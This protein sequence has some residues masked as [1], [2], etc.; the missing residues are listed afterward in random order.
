MKV[1]FTANGIGSGHQL[2]AVIDFD[3]GDN[4]LATF[5]LDD[6]HF[7]PMENGFYSRGEWELNE[8]IGFFKKIGEYRDQH[9]MEG[10]KEDLIGDF[11][12]SLL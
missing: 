3:T 6:N 12:V 1:L 9:K 8:L 11:K 2:K 7:N 5:Y 10:T 4:S